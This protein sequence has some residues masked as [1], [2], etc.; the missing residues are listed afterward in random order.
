M[1]TTPL[2]VNKGT[3]QSGGGV[4]NYSAQGDQA[5]QAKHGSHTFDFVKPVRCSLPQ[6]QS[7]IVDG[8]VKQMYARRVP[9]S[10]RYK[11]NGEPPQTLGGAWQG[12]EQV[13]LG[14]EYPM[15]HQLG[16]NDGREECRNGG[17]DSE[18][19]Q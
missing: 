5:R 9:S 12:G 15:K 10:G 18:Q 1:S 14:G 6:W 4:E 17:R 13:G 7:I 16:G 8:G 2:L 19:K 11:G 3:T